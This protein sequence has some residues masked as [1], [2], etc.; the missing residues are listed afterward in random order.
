MSYKSFKHEAIK[1]IMKSIQPHHTAYFI[2]NEN[3]IRL[4]YQVEG[5]KNYI[6]IPFCDGKAMTKAAEILRD[7]GIIDGFLEKK[8]N[9]ETW[10]VELFQYSYRIH[11]D[12][13][14]NTLKCHTKKMVNWSDLHLTQQDVKAF[15]AH[16]TWSVAKV[17]IIINEG[18]KIIQMHTKSTTTKRT[19]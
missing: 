14:G 15:A 13:K 1:I 7:C 10:D 17:S 8:V 9:N 19:A 6:V 2:K 18:A 11:R 5:Q 4:C 12:I 16:F 3:N